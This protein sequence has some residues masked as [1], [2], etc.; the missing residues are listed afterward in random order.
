MLAALGVHLVHRGHEVRKQLLSVWY[1]LIRMSSNEHSNGEGA[2]VLDG[3][4]RPVQELAAERVAVFQLLEP[5]ELVLD[6]GDVG[7]V[8]GG[9]EG[10]NGGDDLVQVV[11]HLLGWGLMVVWVGAV[12]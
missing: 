6:G 9:V 11:R 7:I 2:E 12:T 3:R 5:L 10:V 1:H 8:F 4:L